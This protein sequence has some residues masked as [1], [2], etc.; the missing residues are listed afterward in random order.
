MLETILF[1]RLILKMRV[2]KNMEK[3]EK[4][5]VFENMN[6]SSFGKFKYWE[7]FLLK[8]CLKYSIVKKSI[9]LRK[10]WLF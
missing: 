7:L 2:K 4:S 10:P 3:L 6:D 1:K 8:K 5:N 9:P